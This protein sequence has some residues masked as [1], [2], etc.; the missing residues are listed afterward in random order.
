MF[1]N[2]T[3]LFVRDTKDTH[4]LAQIKEVVHQ[5]SI[6]RIQKLDVDPR[7]RRECRQVSFHSRWVGT[8]ITLDF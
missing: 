3:Q 4:V 6:F 5:N 8:C 7:F 1:L 2:N